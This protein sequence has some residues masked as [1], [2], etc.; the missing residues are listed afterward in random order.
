MTCEHRNTYVKH[1]VGW[2][3]WEG[4]EDRQHLQI[5]NDCG[6]TRFISDV[7]YSREGKQET[8][9][10]KWEEKENFDE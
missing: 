6:A 8:F 4:G 9:Q 7:S 5:C 2:D 10:G 3:I 1:D